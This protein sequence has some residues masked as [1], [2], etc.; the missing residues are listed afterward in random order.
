MRVAYLDAFSG[1][2]GDMTLGALVHLGLP[3]TR[4]REIPAAL[5][6]D[7]V[8]VIAAR[9]T[10]NGIESTKVSVVDSQHAQRSGHRSFAEI[11]ALLAAAPLVPVARERAVA[12]FRC[13]AEAEGRVHGVAPEEVHFHEVGAV[14]SLVDIVGTAVGITDLGIEALYASPLPVGRGRIET[15]HGVLP[16]PA[17]ATLEVLRGRPVRLED[18]LAELVTPTGAAIVAALT[19]QG[20]PPELRIEAVGY[21]CGDFVFPD[22]P[23]VLRVILGEPVVAPADDEVVCLETNIDDLTPELLGHA[24]ERLLAAGARDVFLSPIQM[25]KSRPATLLRV[26]AD[27]VDRERL[28]RVMFDETSTIGVRYSTL[29]RHTLPRETVQVDT[30]YGAVAVRVARAPDGSVNVAPEFESCRRAAEA[31][32][33]PAKR[34]YQ[35]AVAAYERRPR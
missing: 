6:L 30:P 27:P 23:N 15:R 10:V 11:A 26:L 17:P 12:I 22:R 5:G 25:K 13:L 2:A 31:A 3:L 19:R 8:E 1:I 21:G 18:G 24:M 34:V 35:A 32:G 14:D 7:G 4:L 33:V 16:V 29:R 9:R 20:P 28:V